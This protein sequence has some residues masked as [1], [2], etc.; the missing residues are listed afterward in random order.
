MEP[1]PLKTAIIS[2]FKT[3][4]ENFDKM[5]EEVI[6]IL[7]LDLDLDMAAAISAPIVKFSYQIA[8]ICL[9]IELAQVA[10]KVDLLK[11]EHGLKVCVKMAL[12]VVVI[13]NSM[14]I[15]TAFYQQGCALVTGASEALKKGKPEFVST[16]G[17][18]V[19][20]DVELIVN[21]INDLGAAIALFVVVLVIILAVAACGIIVKVIAYFRIF[22]IIVY[23]TISP[24]PCAFFPLGNGDGSGFS[25]ITGKFLKSFAAVCLQGM[26]IIICIQVFDGVVS[27]ELEKVSAEIYAKREDPA[28]TDWTRL[29]SGAKIAFNDFGRLLTKE[30]DN[31]AELT[32]DEKEQLDNYKDKT[33]F[34]FENN[35]GR[36]LSEDDIRAGRG[37]PGAGMSQSNPPQ[38]YVSTLKPEVVTPLITDLCFLMLIASLVLVMS[39]MKCGGWAKSILEA[40]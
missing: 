22:E 34:R 32:S 15:L 19:N 25:R 8:A 7:S 36:A 21:S 5:F 40:M 9:L 24:L 3:A 20:R 30:K 18:T 13:E 6:T 23:A 29:Y 27:G 26:M 28:N 11:W 16:L 37:Q 33:K 17:Y 12:T 39:I 1:G 35:A 38:V 31:P 14:L 4:T 10:S 2:N